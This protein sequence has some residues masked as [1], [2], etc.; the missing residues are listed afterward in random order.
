MR[1]LN[2]WTTWLAV[3]AFFLAPALVRADES[4]PDAP[5]C[6]S[7]SCATATGCGAKCCEL[8]QEGCCQLI[9]NET[10]DGCSTCCAQSSEGCKKEGCPP[11]GCGGCA[12]AIPGEVIKIPGEVINQWITMPQM[13]ETATCAEVGPK[14]SCCEAGCV[15]WPHGIDASADGCHAWAAILPSADSGDG[16]EAIEGLTVTAAFSNKKEMLWHAL[17]EAHA[18]RAALQAREAAR[19]EALELVLK[20]MVENAKLTAQVELAE[21]KLAMASQM[22]GAIAENAQLK[23]RIEHTEQQ[24]EL[25]GEFME[26][27][28]QIIQ[29]QANNTQLV[30]Q[31]EQLNRVKAENVSLTARV[32]ELERQ[33][34]A[35][36]YTSRVAT[37][38]ED[39]PSQSPK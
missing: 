27:R 33:A 20:T 10:I 36:P 9:I 39:N 37:K 7:R 4:A 15:A 14:M 16:A 28:D 30:Q 21:Q 32:R 23:A 29:L 17:L 19:S 25:M 35:G 13:G 34:N 31:L 6:S 8:P 1:H 18:E 12:P 24:H 5:C 22:M 26:T 38:A 2:S 3:V 11:Q